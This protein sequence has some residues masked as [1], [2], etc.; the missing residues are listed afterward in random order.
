MYGGIFTNRPFEFNL[1]CIVIS[2]FLGLAY[3]LSPQQNPVVLV[4]ILIMSYLAISW[5]DYLYDCSPRMNSGQ[6]TP[7]SIF[8][9]QDRDPKNMRNVPP[10]E[11]TYLRLVYV[12]HLFIVAPLMLYCGVKGYT[13]TQKEPFTLYMFSTLIGTGVLATLYHGFRLFIPRQVTPTEGNIVKIIN[14]TLEDDSGYT[15][16]PTPAIPTLTRAPVINARGII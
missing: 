6:F 4:L 5:Y 8:K 14:M 9:H 15:G 16:A 3:W 10:P 1:K 7:R 12:F 11:Y 13:M 2:L